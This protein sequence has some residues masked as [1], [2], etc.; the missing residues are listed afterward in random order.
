MEYIG[1][2]FKFMAATL[3]GV[4]NY[5]FTK[6]GATINE[7]AE[8]FGVF[9]TVTP[10]GYE[11]PHGH[12]LAAGVVVWLAM[13]AVLVLWIVRTQYSAAFYL[14]P[15]AMKPQCHRVPVS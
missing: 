5:K 13:L 6:R 15:A 2:P 10:E 9:F 3:G 8:K 1:E 12:L 14:S 7:I 11:Q 4:A